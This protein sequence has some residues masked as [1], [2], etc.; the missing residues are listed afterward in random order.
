VCIGL[1]RNKF[2]LVG[3]L[4]FWMPT[5]VFWGYVFVNVF[6]TPRERYGYSEFGGGGAEFLFAVSMFISLF[7]MSPFLLIITM[8]YYVV[9]FYVIA[10]AILIYFY[11]KEKNKS[12]S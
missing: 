4:I 1:L 7:I 5:L 2:L 11:K 10:Y 6:T 8:P 12:S 9:P 3:L